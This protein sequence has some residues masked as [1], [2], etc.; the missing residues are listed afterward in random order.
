MKK[1][2]TLLALAM[3]FVWAAEDS[4]TITVSVEWI[5][6]SLKTA[7]GTADYTNWNIGMVAPGAVNTMTTG[8]G[9]NHILVDNNCN[10]SV[11]FS[12]YSVSAAPGACGRGTPTAWTPGAASGNNIYLLEGGKG[13]VG[14][15]PAT[16]TTF[17]NTS[18]PGDVYAA[19]EPPATDHHLYFRFTAPT[20][21]SDGCD[22]TVMVYVV[23]Q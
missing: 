13:A 11:D 14:A 2:L 19:S 9:G 4:F 21:V 12:I 17:D 23:A 8:T 7:D 18:A 22:H 5:D 15:L 1:I 10:V 20:S 3:V 6:F 16:W